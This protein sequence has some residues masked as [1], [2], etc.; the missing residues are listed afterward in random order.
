MSAA[1]R[2]A[3]SSPSRPEDLAPP[4]HRFVETSLGRLHVVLRGEG[5]PVV[6]WHS[7]YVD[8]RSFDRVAEALAARHRVVTIDG[9]YHGRSDGPGRVFDLEACADAAVE[10]LDALELGEV[11]WIGNAWGGHVGA[12]L[13][14]RS[15]TR[16]RSFVAMCSLMQ[17]VSGRR[18]LQAMVAIYSLLGARGPVRSGL[19]DALLHPERR[20]ADP[21]LE[22]YVLECVDPSDRRGMVLAMRSVMLGRASLVER[23][24]SIRI[25]TLFA[26]SGSE[27]W[28]EAQARDQAAALHD[29]EVVTLPGVWHLPPLEDPEGT[30]TLL[31]RW[32]DARAR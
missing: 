26:T 15:P 8:A 14:A 27:L 24:S 4:E 29:G 16:L 28:G 17:P 1:P 9:P 5:S 13:A 3:S 10:V 6:L 20:A 11:D 31:K 18:K 12:V 2:S 32:L 7:L 22:R 30:T 25:P 19:L 23:L 21:M